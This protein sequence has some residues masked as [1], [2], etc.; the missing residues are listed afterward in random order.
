MPSTV[1]TH[2]SANAAGEPI[3]AYHPF[4]LATNTTKYSST[5]PPPMIP[6]ANSLKLAFDQRPLAQAD[7]HQSDAGPGQQAQRRADPSLVDRVLEEEHRRQQ[8]HRHADEQHHPRAELL[9]ERQ[10]TRRA[11]GFR[12]RLFR[13]RRWGRGCTPRR[14]RHLPDGLCHLAEQVQLGCGLRCQ[15]GRHRPK[16]R[17]RGWR[18]CW[19]LGHGPTGRRCRGLGRRL[20]GQLGARASEPAARVGQIAT[21]RCRAAAHRRP[22][23]APRS[24]PTAT[25]GVECPPRP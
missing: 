14:T 20:R 10:A 2:I 7:H 6:A 11:S 22:A 8:Q 13:R 3:R 17:R 12:V 25:G 4:G 1:T 23:S 5:T 24:A 9:F 16:R 21:R 15:A 18:R 19:F